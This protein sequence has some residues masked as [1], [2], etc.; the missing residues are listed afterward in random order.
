MLLT[1]AMVLT[2]V[3]A[4]AVPVRAA[5]SGNGTADNP[6]LI[7][8]WGDLVGAL[9]STSPTPAKPSGESAG[10]PTYFK[11]TNGCTRAIATVGGGTTSSMKNTFLEVASGRY[12]VLDL[13]GYWIDR[14]ISGNSDATG[15]G[16]KYRE[17]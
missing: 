3:P 4:A 6:Y 9:T 15:N 1:L 12:V 13:N 2:M 10:T 16:S 7:S 11:L 14:N 8:S 17:R 5:V